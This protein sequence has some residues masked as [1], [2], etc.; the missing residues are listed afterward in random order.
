MPS[1]QYSL[2]EIDP[3]KL[4]AVAAVP[5]SLGL[6]FSAQGI[7]ALIN[8]AT[9][10]IV[11]QELENDCE[12]KK[13]SSN[14]AIKKKLERVESYAT[15]LAGLLSDPE[16][17]SS[18]FRAFRWAGLMSFGGPLEIDALSKQLRHIA[19][20][21]REIADAIPRGR[22]GKKPAS[23]RHTLIVSLSEIFERETGQ[24]PTTTYDSEIREARGPVLDLVIGCLEALHLQHK[25]PETLREEIRR[26]LKG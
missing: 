9:L 6:D 25:G 24:S 11:G 22:P 4:D 14:S 19:S 1:N 18:G 5:K 10:F 13:L 2:P 15:G 8:A 3:A 17:S 16:I 23:A 20:E 21:A 26:A 7:D 12:N